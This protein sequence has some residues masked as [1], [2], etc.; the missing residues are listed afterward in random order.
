VPQTISYAQ[1]YEDMHLLR[2]FAIQVTGFY[3]DIGAGHPV[4]D[5]VSLAFY[6]LGR[7]GITVEPNPWLSQ[8][9]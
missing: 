7:R 5:N 3:I 8:L 6:L 1:H 9:S 2:C 4:C